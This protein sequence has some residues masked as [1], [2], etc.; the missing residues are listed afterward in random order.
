MPTFASGGE[1][2]AELWAEGENL[3]SS[4]NYAEVVTKLNDRG[5]S[6]LQVSIVL[7]GV[8]LTILDFDQASALATGL[9]RK[10]TRDLG[11][12]LGDC[13]CLATGRIQGAEIITAERL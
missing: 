9:M 13:A 11:L 6:D 1:R 7:E 12:S 4:V 3:I 2:V 8:P 10:A 5:L